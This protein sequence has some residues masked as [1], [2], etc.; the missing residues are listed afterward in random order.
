MT[1]MNHKPKPESHV[2][3]KQY[4]EFITV[5]CLEWKPV[6]QDDRLKD[7]ITNSM[8]FLRKDNRAIIYAFVIMQNHFHM[9]WQILGD[10]K[11]EE[12]QRDF[13][14]FTGQQILKVLRTENSIIQDELGVNAKDRKRQ[15]WERNSLGVPLCQSKLFGKNLIIYTTTL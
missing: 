3:A 13:L 2:Y 14:K 1:D 12:V 11:R 15:V 8:S 5:T 10:H 4:A 7:I 9:I 6:L